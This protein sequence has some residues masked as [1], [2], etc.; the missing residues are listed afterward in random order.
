MNNESCSMEKTM[1]NTGK[2][3]I[4]VV[5]RRCI[6]GF[7]AVGIFSAAASADQP[8]STQAS[9]VSPEE[10][11]NALITAAKNGDTSKLIVILGRDAKPIVESGDAV[12]DRTDR[13]KFVKTFE[14]EKSLVKIDDSKVILAVGKD[15][16]KFPIPLVKKEGRW[17]FDTE[18]GK[19]EI[20]N[21]RIGR[22]ELSTIQAILAYI[23][24]Q[25]EYY[26]ANPQ[27]AKLLVYAQSFFSAPGKRDGLYYPVRTGENPSPLGERFAR[28]RAAGYGKDR[29]NSAPQAYLGYYYRI[30]K[31]QGPDAPGGAYDYVVRGK[32]FG[33]HAIVAWPASYGNSGVMTF[34]A[35][36]DGTV[37]EKDLGPNTPEAAQKIKKFNPDKTWKPTKGQN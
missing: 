10:A 18:E 29:V 31:G 22:N 25:R 32:M 7:A 6:V 21:R 17:L 5:L 28:A 26:L 8:V 11:F 16:W 36:H 2:N 27:Q 20:L 30:L 12:A 24:A 34:I 9:F 3:F 35:N 1:K 23:D 13:A 37:Y 15:Q 19:E 14:E 33:G 4:H